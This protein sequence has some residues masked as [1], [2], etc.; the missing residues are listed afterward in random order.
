M[1]LA[2]PIIART[3]VAEATVAE[4]GSLH[5]V[6]PMP[7]LRPGAKVMLTISPISE[8]TGENSNPLLGTVMRYDD[9]FGPAAPL[10]E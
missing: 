9:P 6:A 2:L 3:V 5:L 1:E 10:E 8:A 7:A 4:D